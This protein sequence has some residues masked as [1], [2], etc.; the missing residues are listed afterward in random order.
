M[1]KKDISKIR[2]FKNSINFETYT[3]G[4]LIEALDVSKET[5][6]RL[7]SKTITDFKINLDSVIKEDEWNLISEFSLNKIKLVV[8]YPD[9]LQKKTIRVIRKKE[10]TKTKNKELPRPKKVIKGKM[11]KIIYT[12][13]TN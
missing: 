8:S 13:Q 2:R 9:G 1:K 7:I 12:G 3:Y 10:G 11:F 6:E 5:I 4:H